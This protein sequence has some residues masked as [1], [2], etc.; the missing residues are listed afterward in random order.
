MVFLLS[1]L[2]EKTNAW[3][4][5]F[6]PGWKLESALA[7]IFVGWCVKVLRGMMRRR[8]MIGPNAPWRRG[9]AK[10]LG[11]PDRFKRN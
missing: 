2:Y 1:I 11:V 3:I 9:R 8:G 10:V 6:L 7:F 5:H 4:D